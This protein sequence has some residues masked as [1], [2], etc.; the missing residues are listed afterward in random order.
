[1]REGVILNG[2]LV[3]LRKEGRRDKM[4]KFGEQLEIMILPING[5]DRVSRHRM[6]ETKG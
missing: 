4:G 2:F 5:M 1:M 6:R 3:L